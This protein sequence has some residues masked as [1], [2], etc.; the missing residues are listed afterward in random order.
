MQKRKETMIDM[1]TKLSYID[2]IYEIIRMDAI[3]RFAPMNFIL[4]NSNYL[5][6]YEEIFF[7]ILFTK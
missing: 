2:E 1:R 6:E 5:E 4:T 7:E 3:E